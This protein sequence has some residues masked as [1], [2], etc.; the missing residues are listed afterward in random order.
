[1]VG[2]PRARERVFRDFF[3]LESFLNSGEDAP[4][5]VNSLTTITLREMHT[6]VRIG[7]GTPESEKG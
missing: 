3:L 6:D 2:G 5:R 7:E 4:N 1:M